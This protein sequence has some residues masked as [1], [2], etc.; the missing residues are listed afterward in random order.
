VLEGR[1]Q[2]P[3]FDPMGSRTVRKRE[4]IGT[5]F[6]ALALSV[7]TVPV[8]A[9][10]TDVTGRG[11]AAPPP[12]ES[13]VAYDPVD[14][15]Q[16][17]AWIAEG[18]IG[19]RSLAVGVMS[20]VWQT[21]WD[22]P[23]EWNRSWSGVALRYAEREADVTISNTLEAGLGAI[24]GE[25]P[26]YIPSGRHGIGARTRY[27]A[28]TVFLAQRRDGHLAPAWGRYVGN[29]LNN[30]IENAWLPPSMTTPRETLVRSANGFLGRMIGN[31]YEEFWPDAQRLLHRHG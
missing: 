23:P 9:Q 11:H 14:S 2:D 18:S 12:S 13:A 5:A 3:A 25:E 30:V 7:L 6:A 29:T 26:R 20:T 24:W 15:G 19:R 1:R 17:V 8:F 16:R 31:L 4:T 10:D 28:K 22:T 21:A 27:A